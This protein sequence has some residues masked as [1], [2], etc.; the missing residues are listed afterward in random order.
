MYTSG[1]KMVFFV[2]FYWSFQTN[3]MQ[4]YVNL[5]CFLHAH[6]LTVV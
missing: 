3:L 1:N 2:L 5:L 4:I 6:W